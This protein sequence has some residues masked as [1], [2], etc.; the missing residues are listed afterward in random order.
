VGELMGQELTSRVRVRGKA[1]VV[2]EDL[3]THRERLSGQGARGRRGPGVR[4]DPH[5][6]EIVAKP[7]FDGSA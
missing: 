3:V 4:M 6:A 7:G 5:L 1:P 2:E